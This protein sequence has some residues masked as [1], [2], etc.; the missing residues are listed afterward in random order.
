MRAFVDGALS[1]GATPV[2]FGYALGKAQEILKYLSDA[3]YRCAAHPVVHAVNRV[4]EA[5]GVAFPNADADADGR[6]GQDARTPDP[7]TPGRPRDARP[8]DARPRVMPRTR[9]DA[10]ADG[11]G[12]GRTRRRLRGSRDIGRAGARAGAEWLTTCHR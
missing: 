9:T 6:A 11:R 5:H 8:G 3:G 12:R 4:Y 10:D 1:D 2:L 7:R